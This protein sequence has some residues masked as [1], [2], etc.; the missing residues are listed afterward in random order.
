MAGSPFDPVAGE[1]NA[2]RPSYPDAIYDEFE[3]AA[4]TLAGRHHR[5]AVP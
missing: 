5:H 4:G 3:A 1:Y 2:A